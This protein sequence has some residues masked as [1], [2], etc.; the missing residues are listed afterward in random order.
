[1]LTNYRVQVDYEWDCEQL[2][3]HGDIVDHNFATSYA[4]A[5]ASCDGESSKVLLVRTE[6]N[7]DDGVTERSW[8]YV[9]NGRL[10]ERFGDS[11]GRP[12]GAKVPKRFHVEVARAS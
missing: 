7:D 1:M 2:D 5:L 10:P 9:E 4:E 3:K 6:G 8:A 12:T 11:W